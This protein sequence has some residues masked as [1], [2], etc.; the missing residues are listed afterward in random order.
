MIVA[1]IVQ[2]QMVDRV[3][4]SVLANFS[5][6]NLLKCKLIVPFSDHNRVTPLH[7]FYYHLI[8]LMEW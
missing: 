3:V 7:R 4:D 1:I 5:E 6:Q 8:S 2:L